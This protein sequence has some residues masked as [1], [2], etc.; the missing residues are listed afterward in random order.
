MTSLVE[1]L[2][3]HPV[4]ASLDDVAIKSLAASSIERCYQKGASV[5]HTD[6]IWPYFFIVVDGNIEA[7]KVSQ[8]AFNYQR[9]HGW[10]GW[11]S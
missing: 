7:I 11:H 10:V 9:I 6:D 3:T 1:L 4:F 2:L 8:E 5:V